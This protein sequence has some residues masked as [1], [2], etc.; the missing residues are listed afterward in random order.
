MAKPGR[1]YNPGTDDPSP[2]EL[3]GKANLEKGD[4]FALV[5]AATTVFLPIALLFIGLVAL[6]VFVVF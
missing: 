2:E 6:I 4:F 1:R 3:K 5:V